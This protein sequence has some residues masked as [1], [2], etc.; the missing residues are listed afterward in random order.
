MEQKYEKVYWQ[1]PITDRYK[2]FVIWLV[3]FMQLNYEHISIIH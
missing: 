3:Y 1:K 2:A